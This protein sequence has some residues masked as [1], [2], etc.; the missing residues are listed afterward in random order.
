[1]H[2][3][4]IYPGV[5]IPVVASGVT[6][7]SNKRAESPVI[8]SAGQRPAFS[9]PLTHPSPNGAKSTVERGT[10]RRVAPESL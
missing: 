6:G 3:A 7:L 8:N 2:N 5:V 9:K 1:M 10:E 4:G